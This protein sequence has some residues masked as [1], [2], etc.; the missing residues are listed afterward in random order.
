MWRV[1]SAGRIGAVVLALWIS[2]VPVFV[3]AL[4]RESDQASLLAALILCAAVIAGTGA[5]V[6][7]CFRLRI[8]IN[9]VGVHVVN[10]GRAVVIPW[11]ELRGM[12]PGYFGITFFRERGQPIT[13]W[14]VQKSNMATWGNWSTR[15]DDVVHEV[16]ER[17]RASMAQLE[18]TSGPLPPG[19]VVPSEYDM[20]AGPRS[21][22][23]IGKMFVVILIGT[24]IGTL[25]GAIVLLAIAEWSS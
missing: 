14:A 7:G 17:W 5:V 8:G 6:W 13:A 18:G 25:V 11:T 22:Q 19:Y 3:L 16:T 2:S 9:R 4:A 12:E 24:V 1:S 23:R 15:A 21:G 20:P 10:L